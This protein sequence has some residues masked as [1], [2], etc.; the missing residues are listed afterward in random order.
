MKAEYTLTQRLRVFFKEPFGVLILGT[1][2]QTMKQLVEKAAKEKPPVIIA[3]GDVVSQNLHTFNIHP[4]LSIVDGKS[5]RDQPMPEQTAADKIV[6]VEN[7]QSTIT[8]ESLEAVKVALDSG[9]HTHIVVDG[10]EDLLVLPA[11]LHAPENAFIV[12]GQPYVGIVVAKAT[13][14]RKEQV[15]E[16]LKEMKASKS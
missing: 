1:P 16:F 13:K 15:K 2:E 11:I 10:E 3:V 5:L 7:P 8:N 9:M 6:H 14:M 12:Y 4:Q